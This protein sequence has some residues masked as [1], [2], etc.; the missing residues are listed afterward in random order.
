M[1]GEGVNWVVVGKIGAPHG[2]KGWVKL[3][4][5]TDPED[6][7]AS[8]RPWRLRHGSEEKT[9]DVL[10]VEPRG[11]RLVAQLDGFEDR[12]AAAGLTGMEILVDRACFEPT[13]D[14]EYYWSDLLGLEVLTADGVA[15]GR[16]AELLETGAN[17]VLV[18]TGDRRLLIPF[19]RDQVIRSIDTE[20]GRIV[21]DWDPDY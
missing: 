1:S 18:V 17:D 12:D 14:G 11:N 4:S 21:V 7:I 13:A 15:L 2:V 19:I 8:Y 6:N 9:V 16:V 20:A 5:F 10:A 3:N